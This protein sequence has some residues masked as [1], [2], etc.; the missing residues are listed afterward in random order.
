L[1]EGRTFAH[2]D[3]KISR[4]DIPRYFI[5]DDSIPRELTD[6]HCAN[7][8]ARKEITASRSAANGHRRIFQ[9][10]RGGRDL[11]TVSPLP[12]IPGLRA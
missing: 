3:Q 1:L 9:S 12:V 2:R 5:D 6:P 10:S 7:A 4:N 8:A 11:A